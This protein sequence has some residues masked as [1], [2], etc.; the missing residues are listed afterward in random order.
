[1]TWFDSSRYV[2]YSWFNALYFYAVSVEKRF[3][4]YLAVTDDYLV[5]K[6][7]KKEI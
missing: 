3:G 7:T 6:C 5:Q 4:D 2:F 1:M